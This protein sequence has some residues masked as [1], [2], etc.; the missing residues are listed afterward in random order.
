MSL[1]YAFKKIC[2]TYGFLELLNPIIFRNDGKLL[3]G[4]QAF[5]DFIEKNFDVNVND[6]EKTMRNKEVLFLL[7]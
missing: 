5:Y 4:S 1:K 3:G 2:K 6:Y 7:D